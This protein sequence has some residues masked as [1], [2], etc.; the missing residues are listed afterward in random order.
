MSSRTCSPQTLSSI[1]LRR[2]K[3]QSQSIP[4]RS[5]STLVSSSFYITTDETTDRDDIP[6]LYK[7]T[8]C[9]ATKNSLIS[10]HTQ[11][12]HSNLHQTSNNN[13]PFRSNSFS[14]S[15]NNNATNGIISPQTASQIK[16]KKGPISLRNTA[17]AQASAKLIVKNALHLPHLN[18]DNIRKAP[19]T[20]LP[21][22]LSLSDNH[23]KLSMSSGGVDHNTTHF[24]LGGTHC[25]PAPAPHILAEYGE[26]SVY[27]LV[28]LRHGESEWNLENRYTGWCDATLTDRGRQEAR[29]AGRLLRENGIEVDHA[30]TSILKRANFTTNMALNTSHQ[31][32]VPVTKSWRLNERH[33]G[34][35]QGYNKDTAYKELGIDQELVMEMRRSYGTRPPPM[36]D[37]H[38]HW[39]GNDRR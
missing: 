12:Q 17:R 32:W 27:T 2:A 10:F 21:H 4:N 19:S 9:T 15:K 6:K 24:V 20:H 13:P 22:S 29:D 11:K 36:M 25:D 23:H 18:T 26:K 16:T 39:H 5:A 7:R 1:V 34:A 3:S 31:A 14:S 33:Y 38:E 37:D 35:L 8:F 30:F 28:L